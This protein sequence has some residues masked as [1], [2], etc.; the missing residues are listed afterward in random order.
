MHNLLYFNKNMHMTKTTMQA[1][2]ADVYGF[3]E[4]QSI[5]RSG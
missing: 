4:T 2:N 5:E 3:L 1:E